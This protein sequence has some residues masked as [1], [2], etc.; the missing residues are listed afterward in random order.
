MPEHLLHSIGKH[1]ILAVWKITESKEELVR[2]LGTDLVDSGSHNKDSIHWLASR[3]LIKQAFPG[4]EVRL[5][6]DAYN[7]PSLTAGSKAY[8]ISITHSH[9]MAAVL[10][11]L[12]KQVAIDLELLDSRIERVSKKFIGEEEWNYLTPLASVEMLTTIWSAKETLYK[13]YGKKALNFKKQ[14]FIKPF[15]VQTSQI[16]GSIKLSDKEHNFDIEVNRIDAYVLTYCLA[17]KSIWQ[18]I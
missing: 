14:L 12:E 17:D 11:S 2:L 10:I 13:L 4:V 9:Q 7:K 18:D 8:H 15:L 5:M 16:S 1:T 6:K 3:L